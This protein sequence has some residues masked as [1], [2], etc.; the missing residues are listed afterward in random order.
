LLRQ[1]NDLIGIY[2]VGAGRSGVIR[3]IEA[4]KPSPKPFFICH[5]LTKETRRY[6]VSEL[7][8][9]IIDQNAR[10]MAEQSVIG[11][12]GSLASTAPYL[13]RKYI[14]PRVILRENIPVQ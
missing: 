1:T 12:L 5:D 6:L 10:L 9:V 13:I 7:A 8:D 14:E 3:A 11:M 4:I 2:C